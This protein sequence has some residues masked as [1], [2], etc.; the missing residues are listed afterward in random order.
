MKWYSTGVVVPATDLVR[1][2]L[3]QSRLCSRGIAMPRATNPAVILMPP[4]EADE[5]ADNDVV[6]R[7]P[8]P[9]GEHDCRDRD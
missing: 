6:A 5:Q 8:G 7:G 2:S 9:P 1:E 3:N 4:G